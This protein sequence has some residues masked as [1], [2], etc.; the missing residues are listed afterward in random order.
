VIVASEPLR[1]QFVES[2]D[3][4]RGHKLITLIEIV[5]PSNKRTGVDR[6]TYLREQ[7]EVLESDASLI[8]IDLLRAG[9]RLL[10]NTSTHM[11][12]CRRAGPHGSRDSVAGL[13]HSLSAYRICPASFAGAIFLFS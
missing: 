1:H 9:E 13:Q 5:T 8:E 6:R 10:S 7:R 12:Q 11:L 4:S 3:A 2:R